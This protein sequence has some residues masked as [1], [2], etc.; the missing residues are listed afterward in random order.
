MATIEERRTS[1]GELRYRALIRLRGFPAESATFLRKMDAKRWVQQTEAAMREGRYF[2]SSEARKHTV[3]DLVDRYTRD[4]LG[5]R[6]RHR[7]SEL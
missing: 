4:V 6:P 3:A 1:K 2:K 7:E 5:D